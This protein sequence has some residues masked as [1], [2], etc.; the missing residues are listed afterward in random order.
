[1]KALG[2]ILIVVGIAMMVF[3]GF[4]VTTEKKVADLGPIEI[5]TKDTDRIAWPTYVGGL[6]LVGGLVVLVA[7]RKK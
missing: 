6:V 7:G 1:M 5:N 4:N 2:I 3:N